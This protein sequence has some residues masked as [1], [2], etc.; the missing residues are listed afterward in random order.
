MSEYERREEIRKRIARGSVAVTSEMREYMTCEKC[1]AA[2]EWLFVGGQGD[3]KNR[4]LCE[5]CGNIRLNVPYERIIIPLVALQCG[6]SEA[7][8][9]R[10][11]E[12]VQ[13]AWLEKLARASA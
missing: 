11:E 9:R 8:A 6:I 7:E 10:K 13:R 2:F 12:L 1:G 3:W 5:Y 4:I